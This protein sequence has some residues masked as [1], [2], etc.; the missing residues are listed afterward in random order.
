MR[1]E[2]VSID[3]ERLVDYRLVRDPILL[4]DHGAFIAEGRLVVR[5]LLERSNLTTRSILGT[6]VALDALGDIEG[7]DDVP[8]YLV[9]AKEMESVAGYR[10]HQGCLAAA[11]LPAPSSV[12]EMLAGSGPGMQVVV[13]LEAVSNP[14]NVGAIFR[15]AAAFRARGVLL[16]DGCCSPLY[17]KSIRTS[18]GAALVL[19]F[20]MGGDW[21]GELRRLRDLG[22]TLVAM[23]PGQDTESVEALRADPGA[24]LVLLLG[25]E[26]E[27]L[28]NDTLALADR[29]IRIPI[30]PSFDS[31]NVAAAAAVAL[32]VASTRE[33]GPP[34]G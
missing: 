27:G 1:V 32:Y 17:R 14:D 7:A 15:T 31:I 21:H 10:F 30:D 9:D 2:R 11:D 4:R 29:R 19:P 18:M 8:F 20:S 6:Q 22:F 5:I 28:T 25:A 23:T 12:D 13:G 24:R 33:S 3:D 34:P 16:S 26:G